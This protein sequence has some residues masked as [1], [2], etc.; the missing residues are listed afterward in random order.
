MS[1][2]RNKI[3]EVDAYQWTGDIK[4]MLEFMEEKNLT[5]NMTDITQNTAVLNIVARTR[6]LVPVPFNGWIIKMPDGGYD[7][8]SNETFEKYYEVVPEKDEP[9]ESEGEGENTNPTN[10]EPTEPEN[11]EPT[12][13][14]NGTD[15][16]GE[17]E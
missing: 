7:A 15:E 17:G 1:K 2:Y 11:N 3:S 8:M 9:G 4:S 16:P 10:T 5:L 13:P 14:E 6:G 12:E